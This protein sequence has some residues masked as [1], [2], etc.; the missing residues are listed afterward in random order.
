MSLV[1]SDRRCPTLRRVC[2]IREP[3]PPKELSRSVSED[4]YLNRRLIRCLEVIG[5]TQR[6]VP[7]VSQSQTLFGRHSSKSLLSSQSSLR[8]TL[9]QSQTKLFTN[10]ELMNQFSDTNRDK[11]VI[12]RV[13]Q[14]LSDLQTIV[15]EINERNNCKQIED[16]CRT[17]S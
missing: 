5:S 10:R 7:T 6:V 11:E 8:S 13:D 17:K 9:T 1:L 12:E 3:I 15:T 4:L 16:N 14:K 2:C